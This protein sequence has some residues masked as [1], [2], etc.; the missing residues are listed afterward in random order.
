MECILAIKKGMGPSEICRSTY[1]YTTGV[2]LN[3]ELYRSVL[4]TQA[5]RTPGPPKCTLSHTA[6]WSHNLC[7]KLVVC[8]LFR[9]GAAWTKCKGTQGTSLG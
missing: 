1:M 9:E 3:L 5:S 2:M 6:I 7:M 8:E 4:N